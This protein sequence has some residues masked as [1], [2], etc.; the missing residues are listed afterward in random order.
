M[1]QSLRGRRILVG[2]TGG[3]AGYKAAQ[4]VSRLVQAGAEVRVV[5][6]AAACAFV[7]PLTFQALSGQRV[8]TE[9]LAEQTLGHVD[10][11]ELAHW[12]EAVVVAP[13][14]AN[15]IGKLAAG[16]ADDLLTTVLIGTTAPLLL[17]PAMETQMYRSAAVQANLRTLTARD[18]R[19]AEPG[20]GHLA[21]GRSGTGRM[22]EPES[23]LD[24]LSDMLSG[25]G[26]LRGVRVLVT[27]GPT[28][29]WIDP[30]RFLSNPSTGRMGFAVAAEAARRG[31][32][33]VLVAGPT[34]LPTPPGVQRRDVESA[35]EMYE[36]VL[37]A[38]AAGTDVVVKAAAVSDFRPRTY[39][40]RK[41]KKGSGTW[42]LKLENNPDIL[43]ELGRRKR[44][45]I[46]IGFA[47]ETDH[48]HEHARA[49]LV[50]KGLDL[51]VLND[52]G[53]PGAGFA[54]ETNRVDLLWADG[55]SEA[56]PLLSKEEVAR[57]LL[58]EVARMLGRAGPARG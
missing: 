23:L 41:R 11:V 33:V 40:D 56:L 37:A 27:A 55:R 18:V 26:S 43:A 58:D 52:V 14:T 47:A 25:A 20:E 39:H 19:I 38:F 34:A 46:L 1:S 30:V 54:A 48:G 53:E 42:T 57:R 49:K 35:R 7:T 44:G 51:I 4:L 36:A 2:V 28:R 5:M 3:I 12:A 29:E 17:A 13:A 10:H 21:S 31:A 22:A 6:T 32:D 9:L 16:I 50:A 24:M 45:E 15:V 8:F